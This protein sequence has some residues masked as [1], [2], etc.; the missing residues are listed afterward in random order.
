MVGQSQ[1]WLRCGSERL[2]S[3][4][5]GSSHTEFRKKRIFFLLNKETKSCAMRTHSWSF[6]NT[7]TEKTNNKEQQQQQNFRNKNQSKAP[8]P[9]PN[10]PKHFQ[11]GCCGTWKHFLAI[12]YIKNVERRTY[13]VPFIGCLS[14]KA[15]LESDKFH[16]GERHYD[17]PWKSLVL[18][19]ARHFTPCVYFP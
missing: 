14:E 6:T 18:T 13:W 16:I 15:H 11:L 5:R 10:N 9:T 7:K 12:I 17:L 3:P 1:G 2:P 8:P 4:S 19:I